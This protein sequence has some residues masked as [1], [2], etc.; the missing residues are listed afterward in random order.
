[1]YTRVPRVNSARDAVNRPVTDRTRS[2]LEAG[3]DCACTARTHFLLDN[4]RLTSRVAETLFGL[5]HLAQ[6][7]TVPA[8][9]AILRAVYSTPGISW[10]LSFS[11]I[12][13]LSFTMSM[14]VCK[15]WR[16]MEASG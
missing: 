5:A 13:F 8:V 6:P 1:M 9:S 14:I 3:H 15:D 11:S 12:F 2:R 4:G 16:V 10:I 7:H